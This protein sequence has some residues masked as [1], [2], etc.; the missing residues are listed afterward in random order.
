[1]RLSQLGEGRQ[2][3][4]SVAETSHGAVVDAAVDNVVL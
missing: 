4:L 2:Q 3:Y 1:V